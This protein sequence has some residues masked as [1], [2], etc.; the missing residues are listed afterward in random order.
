[1]TV[2]TWNL[3]FPDYSNPMFGDTKSH[4][5]SSPAAVPAGARSSPTTNSCNGSPRR[6]ARAHSPTTPRSSSRHRFYVL[7]TGWD[8]DAAVTVV[9]AGPLAFWHNQ[10]DNGTFRLLAPG[11]QL[12][13]RLGQLRLRRRQ[14]RAGPAQ[15]VPPDPRAQHRDA[16]T[17]ATSKDRFE[18]PAVEGDARTDDAGDRKPLLRGSHPPPGDVLHRRGLLVIADQVSGTAAGKVGVHFNLCPGRIEYA[19]TAPCARSSPTATTSASRPRRPFRAD[20]RGE[21]WVSTAYRKKGGASGLRR[22]GAEGTPAGRC[23]S[24]PSSPRTK[25]RSKARSPSFRKR[26]PWVDTLRFAVRVGAKTYEL[27][28]EPAKM[29][30]LYAIVLLLAAMRRRLRKKATNR[31]PNG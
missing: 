10:P 16:R 20:P 17:T 4:D 30:R 12:L 15:L 18:T 13:P 8:K 23:S 26:P 19:R 24:S 14:R 28:Y 27:G 6:A 3:L 2:V 5:K 11:A 21:G 1:M 22:R 7:R 9:K 29:N 31:C 25:R